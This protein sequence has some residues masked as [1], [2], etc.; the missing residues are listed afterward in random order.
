LRSGWKTLFVLTILWH[1]RYL[2]LLT[3]LDRWSNL[4]FWQILQTGIFPTIFVLWVGS[5]KVR[6][7]FDSHIVSVLNWVHVGSCLLFTMTEGSWNPNN[8][9]K[10]I[11]IGRLSALEC[12]QLQARCVLGEHLSLFLRFYCNYV[13]SFFWHVLIV[14]TTWLLP[15]YC[16]RSY[17][18]LFF[19]YE[20]VPRKLE[21]GLILISAQ[22]SSGSIL[23][24]VAVS[25]WSKVAGIRIT[26][27]NI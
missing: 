24:H 11:M 16:Y 25:P 6:R 22:I 20:L 27:Q 9:S 3:G 19:F 17:F 1:L 21:G 14:D 8:I 5:Q 23:P 4:T 10:H 13:I 15:N 26:Y 12:Y 18:Q 2:L 7:W